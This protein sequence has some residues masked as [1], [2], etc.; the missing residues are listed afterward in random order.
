[1]NM[2]TNSVGNKIIWSLN[3][4]SQLMQVVTICYIGV[5]RERDIVTSEFCPGH[6]SG[7]QP[8]WTRNSCHIFASFRFSSGS[9]SPDKTPGKQDK[10]RFSIASPFTGFAAHR[11]PVLRSSD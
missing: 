5:T 11:K 1:M 7:H 4:T 3:I 8:D 6:V 2:S 9:L 10:S